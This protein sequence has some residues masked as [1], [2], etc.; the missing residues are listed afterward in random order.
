MSSIVRPDICFGGF[1]HV[2]ELSSRTP[3]DVYVNNA[4]KSVIQVRMK[5]NQLYSTRYRYILKPSQVKREEE[6]KQAQW[7]HLRVGQ[8]QCTCVSNLERFSLNVD[9]GQR[10]S[11]L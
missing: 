9:R 10:E 3:E 6:R 5:G 7:K 8:A 11:V 2:V 1:L 4:G